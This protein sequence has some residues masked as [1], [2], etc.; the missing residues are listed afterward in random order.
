MEQVKVNLYI[1]F[2]P[3]DAGD[4]KKL[5]EWLYPMQDEVNI[6]F[7]NPPPPD[8]PL[9]LP[10]QLLLF[11]YRRPDHLA[12]YNRVMRE[13]FERAHIYLFV[14]SQ[15]SM[16]N[17]GIER[18]IT[19]AVKRYVELGERY[20]RIFPV[21]F[22][23]SQWKDKSKLAHFK[24]L[25]PGKPLL[26]I[27][28]QEEGFMALSDELNKVIAGMKRNLNE[29]RQMAG[30]SVIKSA[31]D[32]GQDPDAIEFVPADSANP[33]EWLG[34]VILA[35]LLIYTLY[36][37]RP[38]L[39]DLPKTR[40]KNVESPYSRPDEYRRENPMYPPDETAP[41]PSLEDSTPVHSTRK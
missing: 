29:F 7:Y 28:P 41:F 18:D 27:S 30:N 35:G 1:S 19:R 6:W 2:T 32:F 33:P 36:A 8:D 22:K 11:W 13:R 5:L 34:W 23:P 4:V 25:G 40:F 16:L 39:P 17:R 20:V 38:A 9:T 10:W 37:L 24:P 12:D 21:I 26:S 15:R 14:T 3:E 31:P